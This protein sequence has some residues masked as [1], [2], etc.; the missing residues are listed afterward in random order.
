MV[1]IC[2]ALNH[3]LEKLR[4]KKQNLVKIPPN[5]EI[6]SWLKHINPAK[7]GFLLDVGVL[8]ILAGKVLGQF[9]SVDAKK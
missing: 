6:H 3:W 9:I 7:L 5:Q 2:A 8:K 1:L 4:S